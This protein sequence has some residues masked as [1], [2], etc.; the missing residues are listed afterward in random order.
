VLNYSQN[1]YNIIIYYINNMI[2][3]NV[4]LTVYYIDFIPIFYH[5]YFE[6]GKS[7]EVHVMSGKLSQLFGLTGTQVSSI[8]LSISPGSR[9]KS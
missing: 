3:V 6:L 5:I 8:A 4:L 9:P 7:K 2:F 1:T